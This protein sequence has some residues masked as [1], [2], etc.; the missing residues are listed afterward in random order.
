MKKS[1]NIME[2]EIKNSPEMTLMIK[3]IVVVRRC[4][5]NGAVVACSLVGSYFFSPERSRCKVNSELVRISYLKGNSNRFIF[6][7]NSAYG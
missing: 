3:M 6:H 1:K 2:I 4:N 5:D 7:P